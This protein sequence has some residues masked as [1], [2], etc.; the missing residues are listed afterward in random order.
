VVEEISGFG[1]VPRDMITVSHSSSYSQNIVNDIC[2]AL[3]IE[4][5]SSLKDRINELLYRKAKFEHKAKSYQNIL[6]N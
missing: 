5:L 1:E 6:E 3:N 2:N 4:S